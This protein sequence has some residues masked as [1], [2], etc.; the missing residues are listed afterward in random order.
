LAEGSASLM[1]SISTEGFT[2]TALENIFPMIVKALLTFYWF[3]VFREKIGCRVW[4]VFLKL[5]WT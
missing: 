1:L 4:Y 3:Y 2:Y 5:D